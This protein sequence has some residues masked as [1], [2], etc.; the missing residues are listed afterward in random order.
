MRGRSVSRALDFTE[1]FLGPTQSASSF[2][3]QNSPVGHKKRGVF[4]APGEPAGP[5][6]DLKSKTLEQIPS[7]EWRLNDP[8]GMSRLVL[9]QLPWLGASGL[10]AR[11]LKAHRI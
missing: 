2:Q 10:G 6:L 3:S 4:R 8:P 7:E 11:Y 5:K 9:K 1:K